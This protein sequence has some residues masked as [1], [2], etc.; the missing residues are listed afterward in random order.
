LYLNGFVFKY[1]PAAGEP[2]PVGFFSVGAQ[3]RYNGRSTALL[4]NSC[5]ATTTLTAQDNNPITLSSIDLAEHN[6]DAAVS[7]TFE[8]M[9]VDGEVVSKTVR[10]KERRVWETVHFP[11]TFKNLRFVRWTQ[12]DCLVNPPHMFDNVKVHPTWKGRAH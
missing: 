8:G 9:T 7:V 10:L 12:G 4:A 5:S 1:A 2:Y 3:W 11:N 6:G